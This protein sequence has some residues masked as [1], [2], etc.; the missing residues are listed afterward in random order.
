MTTQPPTILG[1]FLGGHLV[2]LLHKPQKVDNFSWYMWNWP[3]TLKQNWYSV[4]LTKIQTHCGLER[5]ATLTKKLSMPVP[6]KATVLGLL[7]GSEGDIHVKILI[8]LVSQSYCN[9]SDRSCTP[10]LCHTP[11]K[12]RRTHKGYLAAFQL[13]RWVTAV[14]GKKRLLLFPTWCSNQGSGKFT[15]SLMNV[16]II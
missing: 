1:A 6:F 4:F 5:P 2:V 16:A 11:A 12:S 8:W 9:S 10:L 15:W 7:R 13:Q 14:R 3:K